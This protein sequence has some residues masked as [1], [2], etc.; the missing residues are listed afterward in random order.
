MKIKNYFFGLFGMSAFL[1]SCNSNQEAE[2][3]SEVVEEE[4]VEV[5]TPEEEDAIG[6]LLYTNCYS[7]HTPQGNKDNRIAPPMA[8]VKSHYEGEYKTKAEFI[9]AMTAYVNAPNKEN[10]IMHGAVEKFGVM[11]N[12]QYPKA[13][14]EK[15]V[16]YIYGHELDTDEWMAKFSQVKAPTFAEDDYMGR[17]RHYVM[18]TKKQ[19]G[20]NLKGAIKN[21]GTKGAV[22][23][24]NTR[25]LPIVDS[26]SNVHNATIVRVSDKNRNPN[27]Q[28]TAEETEYI[29]NYQAQLDAQEEL[30]PIL[31][32]TD[33][34]ATFY[35]PIVTN[36]MCIQ[37]HGPK[38]DLDAEVLE[39]IKRLYPNDKAF[40]YGIDQIRGI[41]RVEIQK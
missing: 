29:K 17:G 28:A 27:N 2:T 11:P 41:W 20:K 6:S 32:E 7:C 13:D 9:E 3:V 21:K 39:E 36:D 37:C 14:V 16:A 15:I 5:M 1:V 33:E 18:T 34:L 25:A 10:A 12:M 22:T 26:M 8:H 24:C 23:F 4:V 40:G 30:K 38:N 35:M 19:L 31:N